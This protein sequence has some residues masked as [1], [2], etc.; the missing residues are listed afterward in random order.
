MLELEVCWE[1]K[2]SNV[3]VV[4]PVFVF[5]FSNKLLLFTTTTTTNNNNNNNNN[6]NC[7]IFGKK[8]I[9]VQTINWEN[10]KRM[11]LEFELDKKSL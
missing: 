8:K 4:I 10:D 6:Y 2:S 7:A 1:N 11:T 9:I 3:N 5:H